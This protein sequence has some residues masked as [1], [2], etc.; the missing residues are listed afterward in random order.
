MVPVPVAQETHV[1]TTE[2]GMGDP[3]PPSLVVSP[4]SSVI[5]QRSYLTF[6]AA[7]EGCGLS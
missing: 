2:A 1:V 5:F 6:L 4:A 7:W 3:T